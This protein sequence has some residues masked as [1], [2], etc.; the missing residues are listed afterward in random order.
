[1]KKTTSKSDEKR[2][3]IQKEKKK[4]TTVEKFL[5]KVENKKE[6]E[7][8]KIKLD[9]TENK[10]KVEQKNI[11]DLLEEKVHYGKLVNGIINY[12]LA[13]KDLEFGLLYEARTDK[14]ETKAKVM[15]VERKY[16]SELANNEKGTKEYRK[17]FLDFLEKEM[18]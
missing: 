10:I 15:E 16:I 9:K 17:V 11:R 8:E 7:K 5:K 1:M 3:K 12:S 2:L 13:P 14:H 18:K 6:F 4:E